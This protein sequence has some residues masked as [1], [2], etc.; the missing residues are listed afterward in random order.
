MSTVQ[1]IQGPGLGGQGISPSSP[2]RTL[3]T[4]FVPSVDRHALCFYTVEISCTTTLLSGADGVIELRSDAAVTPTTVR[5]SVRNRMVQT[6][7]VT[8]GSNSVVRGVLSFLV[9]RGESVR[10][11]TTTTVG[12]PVFTL[13]SSV[14]VLL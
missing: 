3:N 13:V 1:I 12:A 9:P 8:L 11:V 2:A 6:L 5:C 4:N 7:G 10:L 14:E